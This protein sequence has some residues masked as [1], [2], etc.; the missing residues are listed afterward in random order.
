MNN[1]TWRLEKNIYRSLYALLIIRW[2]DSCVHVICAIVCEEAP[3]LAWFQKTRLALA[4]G[5]TS[6]LVCPET[7]QCCPQTTREVKSRRGG[8]R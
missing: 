3:Q 6:T 4:L 8:W 2:P 5:S 1:A 7:V